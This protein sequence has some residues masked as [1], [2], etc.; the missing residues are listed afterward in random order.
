MNAMSGKANQAGA[1]QGRSGGVAGARGPGSR[2][3]DGSSNISNRVSKNVVGSGNKSKMSFATT[4]TAPTTSSSIASV[5]SVKACGNS[6]QHSSQPGSRAGSGVPQKVA[7]AVGRIDSSGADGGSGSSDPLHGGSAGVS[8]SAGTSN[9]GHHNA[10]LSGAAPAA[11]SPTASAAFGG[12]SFGNERVHSVTDGTAAPQQQQQQHNKHESSNGN[13]G[14]CEAP[15]N[16]STTIGGRTASEPL[17]YHSSHGVSNGMPMTA[18]HMDPHLAAAQQTHGRTMAPPQHVMQPSMMMPGHHHGNSVMGPQVARLGG[19]PLDMHHHLHQQSIDHIGAT[20]AQMNSHMYISRP[21]PFGGSGGHP[22]AHPVHS[23]HHS[24]MMGGGH[25]H[26][27]GPVTDSLARRIGSYSA[28]YNEVPQTFSMFTSASGSGSAHHQRMHHGHDAGA[29]PGN[30][31]GHHRMHH[32]G[33]QGMPQQPGGAIPYPSGNMGNGIMPPPLMGFVAH[34]Q[35]GMSAADR[36]SHPMFHHGQHLGISNPQNGAHRGATGMHLSMPGNGGYP[37]DTRHHQPPSKQQ[38][39]ARPQQR[40]QPIPQ[41]HVMGVAEMSPKQQQGQQAAL[42]QHN[43]SSRYQSFLGSGANRV[44]GNN[45]PVGSVDMTVQPRA[46]FGSGLGIIG[47]PGGVMT[48]GDGG[49]G[50][51]AS[52]AS[53]KGAGSAAKLEAAGAS[54]NKPTAEWDQQ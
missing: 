26:M 13:I 36:Y 34:G 54:A 43:M 7:T 40:H 48:S 50:S 29:A 3:S 17:W 47:R 25:G 1:P 46:R 42:R 16:G 53:P 4:A 49:E 2:D 38:M 10:G 31:I 24:Q 45:A 33:P 21:P 12:R 51:G 20:A 52:S 37:S 18:A 35:Q 6:N 30:G 11:V 15:T 9:G 27:N 22:M 28:S 19:A 32:V 14:N 39:R 44:R 8:P 23:L 41:Q 5:G